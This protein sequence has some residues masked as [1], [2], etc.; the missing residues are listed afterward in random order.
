MATADA[1]RKSARS[2]E[3]GSAGAGGANGGAGAAN[4]HG[5]PQTAVV[6]PHVRLW[7]PR[8]MLEQK[9]ATKGIFSRSMG[10]FWKEFI[11][12]VNKWASTYGHTGASSVAVAG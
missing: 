6:L 8:A 3:N 1:V 11:V 2:S 5:E 4:R 10:T 9:R 7:S 12:I